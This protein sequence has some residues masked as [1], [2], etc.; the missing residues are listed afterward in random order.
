MTNSVVVSEARHQ[1][2]Y[3][4]ADH[5]IRPAGE[6]LSRVYEGESVQR[7]EFQSI[8]ARPKLYRLGPTTTRF[9]FVNHTT[10]VEPFLKAGFQ[11][12]KVDVMR[13]GLQVL[14]QLQ[15]VE[16]HYY[17]DPVNWD[18]RMWQS[19]PRDLAQQV[20]EGLN[21]TVAILSATRPKKAISFR[22]GWFRMICSN[23]MVVQILGLGNTRMSHTTF[24]PEKVQVF[25]RSTNP[26]IKRIGEDTERLLGPW[27]GTKKGADRLRSVITDFMLPG[28]GHVVETED[29]EL[30]IDDDNII[31]L[32]PT[33]LEVNVPLFIRNSVRP[34]VR[35]PRWF[36]Q[37]LAVQLGHIVDHKTDDRVYAMDIV[38]AIT[39][40]ISRVP[41]GRSTVRPLMTQESVT[42]SLINLVGG[43]SL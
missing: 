35:Q 28:M 20:E 10:A 36:L 30:D 34:L 8:G 17:P 33:A 38:N 16:P 40:P 6:M 4:D 19:S 41:S 1:V 39:N 32:Q 42:T 13:G 5:M 12:T 23:G 27:V 11:I 24:T 2:S 43:M 37:D 29:D 25:L 21:E 22:R 14:T 7:H 18:H 9:N 26:M 3:F 15:P 31:D